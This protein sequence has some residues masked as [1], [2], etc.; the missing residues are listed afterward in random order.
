MPHDDT[1]EPARNTAP[2]DFWE[3]LARGPFNFHER[4][5]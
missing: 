3:R 2:C 1:L 4:L 5:A